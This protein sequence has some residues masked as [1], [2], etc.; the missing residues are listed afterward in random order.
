MSERL[1]KKEKGFVEDIVRGE[2]GTQAVLNHYDTDK[3]N[4]A[5]SIASQNLTKLKIQNAI[6]EALPD[7]MLGEKHRKLFE[8]KELA[9]FTFSKNMSDEEIEGHVTSAGLQVII[10][11]P[12]DKGKLAFYSI[13]NSQAISKALD[14]AY[15]VKGTYAPE[16]SIVLDIQANITDPKAQELAQEYEEKLKQ[17]L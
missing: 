6:Q 16:K 11:R 2:T 14:M 15:K 17:G 5:A 3:E 8:Q 10:I 12:S 7:E 1:S 4:V 13:D 9:Y